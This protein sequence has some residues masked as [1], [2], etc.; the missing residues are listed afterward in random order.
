MSLFVNVSKFL[1]WNFIYTVAFSIARRHAWYDSFASYY[2]R[3]GDIIEYTDGKNRV[4]QST[5]QKKDVLERID[6]KC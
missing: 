6:A 1:K 4:L 3:G 5:M 2:A